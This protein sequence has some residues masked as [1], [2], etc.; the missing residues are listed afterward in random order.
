MF[1]SSDR[2]IT[3]DSR[4]VLASQRAPIVSLDAKHYKLVDQIESFIPNPPSLVGCEALTIKG[5]VKLLPNTIFH[6]RVMVVNESADAREL[7]ASLYDE[8][9]VV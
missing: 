4:V 1:L 8:D 6:G 5:P 3:P 7:P 2:R 9:V